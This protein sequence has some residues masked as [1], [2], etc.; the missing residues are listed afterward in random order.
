MLHT[1]LAC[2]LKKKRINETEHRAGARTIRRIVDLVSYE[3]RL[4]QA[5][6][7]KTE[8]GCNFSLATDQNVSDRSNIFK[9]P[10]WLGVFNSL[11]ERPAFSRD[12]RHDLCCCQSA[13][14][15]LVLLVLQLYRLNA[16]SFCFIS[17]LGVFWILSCPKCHNMQKSTI[18]FNKVS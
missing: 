16:T 5:I 11:P 12:L 8:T 15:P 3:K 4:K 18:S 6:E 14:S 13:G 9:P 2:Y 10:G 1:N 7:V 17:A